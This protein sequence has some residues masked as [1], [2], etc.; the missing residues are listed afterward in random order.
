MSVTIK[1]NPKKIK[2]VIKLFKFTPKTFLEEFNR[3][4]KKIT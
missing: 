1:I 4:R 3:D 2:Y